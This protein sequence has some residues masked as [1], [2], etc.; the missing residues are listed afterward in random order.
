LP[1]LKQVD[2]VSRYNNAFE[3]ASG[4][5]VRLSSPLGEGVDIASATG[6]RIVVAASQEGPIGA[7]KVPTTSTPMAASQWAT[8]DPYAVVQVPEYAQYVPSAQP[9]DFASV[10]IESSFSGKDLQSALSGIPR[11]FWSATGV[12][13]LGFEVERQE[14]MADGSWGESAKIET[15]PHTPTPTGAILEDAG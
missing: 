8:L 7:L 3:N 6:A 14:L 13:I 4:G 11:R 12:A 10:T 9:F 15:P 2:L 1:Q 5:L